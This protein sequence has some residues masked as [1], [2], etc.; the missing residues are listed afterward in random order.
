MKRY[1]LYGVNSRDFLT[2]GGLVLVHDNAAELE[3]LIA[4]DAV[5]REIPPDLPESQTC[6]V[7]L[8]PNL[9]NVRWPLS[10]EDFRP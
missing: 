8:H 1:G 3:F 6:P 9:A 10:R 7:R 5:V 4:G 2:Y